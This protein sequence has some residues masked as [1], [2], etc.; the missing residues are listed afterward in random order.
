MNSKISYT[1]I[2]QDKFSSLKYRKS[3]LNETDKNSLKVFEFC[4]ELI[5]MIFI[6]SFV[7]I[8]L[9]ILIMNENEQQ[10]NLKNISLGNNKNS[11]DLIEIFLAH[12]WCNLKYNIIRDVINSKMKI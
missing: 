6:N 2:C 7:L 8:N 9:F 4:I 11:L 5:K 1:F 3:N 10:T 12:L